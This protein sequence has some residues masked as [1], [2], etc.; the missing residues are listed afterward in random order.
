MNIF[1]KVKKLFSFLLIGLGMLIFSCMNQVAYALDDDSSY[2]FI[3]AGV[4]CEGIIS[5]DIDYTSA[6]TGQNISIILLEDF[7]YNNQLIA[8]SD[9]VISGNITAKNTKNGKVLG[10]KIRF[11]SIRTPYNNVIPVNSLVVLDN[12]EAKHDLI[13]NDKIKLIF[14]QP[15]TVGAK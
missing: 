3:P 11:T 15:I 9:S 4:K 12:D 13:A 6:V 2:I 1:Y 8:P 7:Q 14:N 5:E 10:L